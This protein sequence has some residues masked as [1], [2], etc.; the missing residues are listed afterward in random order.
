MNWSREVGTIVLSL[1]IPGLVF[2]IQIYLLRKTQARMK[3][4]QPGRAWLRHLVAVP[5]VVFNLALIVLIVFRFRTHAFPRWVLDIGLY[6]FFFWHG[7]TIFIGLVLGLWNLLILPLRLM[8]RAVRLIPTAR[9]RIASL[10]EHHTY[11]RFDASRRRFL[12][13]SAY[14]VAA[15]SFGGAAYGMTIGRSG[16]EITE[17]EFPITGLPREFDG[18][19]IALISDIHSGAFM[20]REDMTEYARLVNGLH[21][22]MIAVPGD[23]VN[24]NVREIAPFAEAFSALQAPSGVFGVLGNHDYYTGSPDIVAREVTSCGIRVLRNE[25]IEVRKNG[26]SLCILGVDDVGRYP[27]ASMLMDQA[28]A[29]AP[30]G[31][32]R[33]LLCHR[34]YFLQE[35]AERDIGLVL[36]GHTH[37]GQ[38]VFGRFGN[39]VIAPARIASPYIWGKYRINDSHMYVSRGVGTV[40]LPVRINCPPEITRITLRSHEEP[41]RGEQPAR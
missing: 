13:R 12:Q 6:P 30:S 41:S 37:G 39:T 26:A 10:Q 32:S 29:S 27:T 28:A 11:R 7:S 31:T 36:S 17:A 15:A 2:G 23:F 4:A 22:D 3:Q 25:S 18:F 21:A 40:G 1:V 16:H 20:S 34:P 33:I 9:S 5:F 14:G 24:A 35:A 19:T 38:V 8:A